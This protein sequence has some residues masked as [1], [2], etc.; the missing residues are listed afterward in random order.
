[1]KTKTAAKEKE[2]AVNSVK[3][4]GLTLGCSRY[5]PKGSRADLMK[6]KTAAKEEIIFVK[7]PLFK[8]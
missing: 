6:T 4:E 7:P 2:T 8:Y 1:M 5:P 3:N